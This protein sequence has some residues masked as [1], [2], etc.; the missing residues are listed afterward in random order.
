MAKGKFSSRYA[1]YEI[2]SDDY[3]TTEVQEELEGENG[4]GQIVNPKYK[5]LF[6]QW[7]IDH[8]MD[9]TVCYIVW[10]SW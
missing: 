7:L 3:C 5:P 1:D 9:P 6:K 8:N 4:K 10:S 2:I